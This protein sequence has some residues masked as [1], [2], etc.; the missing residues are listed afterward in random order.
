MRWHAHFW[1]REGRRLPQRAR[2]HQVPL[3]FFIWFF[4]FAILA[5]GLGMTGLDFLTSLSSA[6]TSI[7]NVGPALGPITGPTGT[8]HDLPDAAKWLMTG[9]MLL[10]RL[11]LFTI[12]VLF[13]K[14]FWQ[15]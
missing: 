13:T 3:R 6:A 15:S 10:G 14:T 4:T 5:L 11:E 2:P 12:I 9:G 1:P 8:F 7:A